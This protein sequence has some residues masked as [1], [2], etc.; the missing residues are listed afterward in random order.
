MIHSMP[1]RRALGRAS[2]R[3]GL[4]RAVIVDV[5][6]SP[7]GR[8]RKGS[9]VGVRPDDLAAVVLRALLERVPEVDPKTIDD[10]VCGCAFPFGEQGYNVGRNIALLAGLP[11]TVP[12]Q[13]ITRLC[14]SSMQALR[15]AAHAIAVGEGTT[16]VVVGVESFSRV[17]RGAELAP[18]NPRLDPSTEG[19]TIA[20][21]HIPMGVT[22]ENVADRYGVTREEMDQFA[23]RSQERAV[24]SQRSGF[25]D[26][27]IVPIPVDG[28]LFDTE[29]GPRPESSL[30]GL[31]KLEP[32]FREGGRVTAGNSC[33]LN[34]GAVAALVVEEEHAYALGLL[35]RA[36]ILGSAVSAV[37]P[38]YMGIGP[39]AAIR[40]VLAR[41]GLTM[42]EIA[43]L[44]LNEAFAAQ[45]IPVCREVGVDPFSD[46]LNPHGGA[47]AL[48]HPFGMTGLRL[49]CALLNGLDEIDAE[50]GLAA[51]CVGGGQ[52]QAMLLQ[53]FS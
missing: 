39:V 44:E 9:L 8:A 35:P 52:G 21:V 22:A 38:A 53:R 32:V 11:Q 7:I 18:P 47:I 49:V 29:E 41:A 2:D 37:D 13:T 51:L 25:A 26:R 42:N 36:R 24:A 1:A 28:R 40:T 5:L 17:G 48:G 34:D 45:V 30:E 10:F 6:R 15:S 50:L 27:E 3:S 19:E 14:A 16:F 31:A 12:A 23:Q 20:S 33:Q 43:V 46:V 4:R